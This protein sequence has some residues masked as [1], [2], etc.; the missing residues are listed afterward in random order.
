MSNIVSLIRVADKGDEAIKK[1]VY[2][3][4]NLA[5]FKFPK[6][7]KKVAIKPTLC[8]YW[9]PS[10][11]ETTNPRVVSA[12]INFIRERGGPTSDIC[13]V[14][15][16]ATVMRAKF[17]FK[18]LGYEDLADE[19]KVKLVNLSEDVRVKIPLEGY[20]FSD[21][22][23][24]RTVYEADLFISVPTLK[25]HP[26]TRLSCVL[27]NQFGC[28]PHQRKIEYHPHIN[29][30]IADLNSTMKPDLCVVDGNVVKGKTP[31]SFGLIMAGKDPVAV[32]YVAARIAG[33]NPKCIKYL[34]LATK[35]GIGSIENVTI[36][37]ERLESLK[38]SFP[39]YSRREWL[40]IKYLKFMRVPYRLYC[41]ITG[42]TELTFL[43]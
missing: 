25:W 41:R 40:M 26:L 10:T 30:V 21:I 24:P 1:A 8:Y 35:R 29:E 18:M 3:S 37:G 11:G 33:F 9:D 15:S 27:K 19:E 2:K 43:S 34:V 20:Y 42:E 16:D 4:I 36:I 31:M 7:I 6:K 39:K 5:G 22:D 14:E 12:I 23:V 38:R 28:I 17:A 13:I 32:D